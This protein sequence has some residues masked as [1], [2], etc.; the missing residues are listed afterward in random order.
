MYVGSFVVFGRW[1][2]SIGTEIVPACWK[3]AHKLLDK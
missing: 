1:R 3:D 2:L